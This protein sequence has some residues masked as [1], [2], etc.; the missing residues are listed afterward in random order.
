V[1][2]PWEEEECDMVISNSYDLPSTDVVKDPED[3]S[4]QDVIDRLNREE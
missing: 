3:E 2:M 4:Y 1:T